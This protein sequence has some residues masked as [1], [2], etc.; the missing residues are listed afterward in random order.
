[1]TGNNIHIVGSVPLADAETVF[2][3][4]ADAIG[5]KLPRLPDGETGD[6]LNW[7]GWLA[8]LFDAHEDFE[9]VE[10]D[11]KVHEQATVMP[12]FR[13]KPGVLADNLTFGPLGYAAN[14]ATSY[15]TFARLKAT[16][17]IPAHCRFQVDLVPAHTIIR[18]FV[19]EDDQESVEPHYDA[20]VRRE[21][22]AIADIAPHDQLSIQFDVASAV[23]YRLEKNEPTRYG[24][25]KAE[26]LDAFTREVIGLGQCV[27][28]GVELI[29][30]LCYGDNNHRHSIEPTDTADMVAFA[31]L[32]SGGV[33]RSIELFHMPVPR[34]RTDD[35]YFAPLKNLKLH[36]E[37]GISLGLVHHTDGVAGTRA[38][39]ATAEK[40][41][42]D[43]FI[44]TECGFGR[45]APDTI[46]E[47]LRI[48][49]E[50][51]GANND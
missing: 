12:S 13:L 17:T 2:T 24:A 16:G 45:R 3:A 42:A 20:A 41:L 1:M 46:P 22:A 21:I 26:M 19:H 14:A 11:F 44:A 15:E 38:R 5:T 43:F 34:G 18:T 31:N 23:F 51:A 25:T 4:L 10:R 29:Y 39:M 50:I 49:A 48:H 9:R 28:D 8:G 36:P 32:V 40:Y 7:I 37:T 33:A 27:P 6:R 35:G 47:L 30:H